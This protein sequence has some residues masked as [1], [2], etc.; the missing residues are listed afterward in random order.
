MDKTSILL[1]DKFHS[2]WQDA[3]EQII[4]DILQ[5]NPK[6]VAIIGGHFMLYYESSTRQL[7]PMIWQDSK[8]HETIETSKYYA[9]DFPVNSF[10]SS[11]TLASAL[12]AESIQSRLALLVN[13]HQFPAFSPLAQREHIGA[14][15]RSLRQAFYRTHPKLTYS[16]LKIMD[17]YNLQEEAFILR[18]D[19]SDRTK[20]DTVPKLTPFFSETMM[21][22][23]FDAQFR[24]KFAT[25]IDSGEIENNGEITIQNSHGQKIRLTDGKHCNC[26]G[27]TIPFLDLLLKSFTTIVFFVPSECWKHVIVGTEAALHLQNPLSFDRSLNCFLVMET[28]DSIQVRHIKY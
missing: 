12:K 25:N 5:I 1:D 19:K 7:V 28:E 2:S 9:G 6:E 3:H 18:N 4:E 15:S 11:C 20:V 17:K 23:R 14:Q 26:A 24:N 22:N 13:D 10:E 16:F 21:R 27:E 8:E